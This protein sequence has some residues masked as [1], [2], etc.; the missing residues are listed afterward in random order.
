MSAAFDLHR[1]LADGVRDAAGAWR[2]I[3]RF[4]AV[5]ATPLTGS[6]GYDEAELRAAEARL[7]LPLPAALREL[8]GLV[9]RRDELAR[10]Q[11]I[12]LP[13]AGLKVADDGILVFRVEAQGV[14][15][16]GVPLDV[17]AQPDPPVVFQTTAQPPDTRAW[18]PFLDR[19]SLAGVEMVL[20][21]WMWSGGRYH[22]NR[23]LHR[24]DFD[25][26]AQRFT[27]LPI[28]DYPLWADP[29]GKP[30]RWFWDADVVLRTDAGEWV[31]VR[32]E[33]PEALAAVRQGL[34]GDWL[35]VAG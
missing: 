23:G 6:D 4:A 26:L 12:L 3:R 30:S 1:E 35:M 19:V 31:W 27:R 18:L 17:V 14:A 2:F 28:P 32:A 13:P 8:H 29:H 21:E 10:A 33:S 7:G 20:S 34:P 16:R 24:E 15:Y 11:D 22:D 25:A 5:Y 9:G